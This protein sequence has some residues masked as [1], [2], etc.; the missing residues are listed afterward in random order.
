MFNREFGFYFFDQQT[1]GQD[2]DRAWSARWTCAGGLQPHATANRATVLDQRR[3]PRLAGPICAGQLRALCSRLTSAVR[4]R[5]RRSVLDEFDE[6]RRLHQHTA[7]EP[8]K[9]QTAFAGHSID[10]SRRNAAHLASELNLHKRSL[11]PWYLGPFASAG[12]VGPRRRARLQVFLWGWH[13][14]LISTVEDTY[15]THG[16]AVGYNSNFQ[17]I[18]LFNTLIYNAFSALGWRGLVVIDA[19]AFALP[20]SSCASLPIQSV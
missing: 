1:R 9:G 6:P 3:S 20:F 15:F 19:D 10:R 17:K 11:A 7:R 12:V 14:V 5:P 18:G 8:D 4:W 16:L 13:D 2:V